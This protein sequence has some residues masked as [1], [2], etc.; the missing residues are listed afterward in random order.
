MPE[1][2]CKESFKHKDEKY[3]PGDKINV[4]G[5]YAEI[6]M[7][8]GWIGNPKVKKRKTETAT[9]NAENIEKRN[10]YPKTLGGGWYETSNGEKVRGKDKAIQKENGG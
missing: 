6:Y 3:K 10:E 1:F 8:N 7:Q 9:I 5:K 4:E 2:E